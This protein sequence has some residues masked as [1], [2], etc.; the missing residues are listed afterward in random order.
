MT[1]L[2]PYTTKLNASGC[3]PGTMLWFD[4]LG[5]NC[6]AVHPG[7]GCA[8]Q[9]WEHGWMELVTEYRQ[10][11][12]V[13]GYR[14]TWINGKLYMAGGAPLQVVPGAGVRYR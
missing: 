8:G 14:G 10:W 4:H 9:S 12:G 3:V 7:I 2:K 1:T 6:V 13:Q 5:R 11:W